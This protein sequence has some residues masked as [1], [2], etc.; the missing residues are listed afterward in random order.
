MKAILDSR[1]PK[2]VGPPEASWKLHKSGPNA[3]PNMFPFRSNVF[4]SVFFMVSVWFVTV[5]YSSPDVETE[6]PHLGPWSWN[7][8]DTSFLSYATYSQST[9]CSS[10]IALLHFAKLVATFFSFQLEVLE[11]QIQ[12]SHARFRNQRVWKAYTAVLC[13]QSQ[14]FLKTDEGVFHQLETS[15]SKLKCKVS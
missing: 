12:I 6:M 5:I 3:R 1:C 15:T 2:H 13:V 7:S 8:I 9:H 4:L 10:K 14:V 11:S